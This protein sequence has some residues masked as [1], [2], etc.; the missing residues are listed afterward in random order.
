MV[1][2][3]WTYIFFL[4]ICIVTPISANPVLVPR[5][6]I[7]GPP[8]DPAAKPGDGSGKYNSIW[9]C[10]PNDWKVKA[11]LEGGVV[12]FAAKGWGEASRAMNHYLMNDGTDMKVNL[13]NMMSD[14]P[15][16]KNAVHKLAQAEAKKRVEE[17]V[18]PWVDLAFTSDWKVWHAWN[19]K[20]KKPHNYDWYYALGEYSYAV[21]GT[22][23]R[24]KEGVMTLKWKAHAFDRYNW[25]KN[26]KKNQ[27]GWGIELSH[28]EIGHLHK[29]GSAREYTVRGS[30]KEQ[31]V[32]NYKTNKPLPPVDTSDSEWWGWHP[33]KV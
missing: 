5:A 26:T 4:A 14:T 15:A 23:H 1:S 10:G 12:A 24:N 6:K 18:G 30:S 29:C 27:L 21:S 9:F 3:S 11:I 28:A 17:F 16:F 2:L 32:K 25:D 7:P 22:I 33:P 20:E 19:D 8:R 13:G 31:L